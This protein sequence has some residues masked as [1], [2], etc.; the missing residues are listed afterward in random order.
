MNDMTLFL[1]LTLIAG[2]AY[3]MY[4]FLGLADTKRL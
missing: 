1:A 3:C 4:T 2:G